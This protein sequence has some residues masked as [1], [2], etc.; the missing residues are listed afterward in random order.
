MFQKITWFGPWLV[1]PGFCCVV[2]VSEL[3]PAGV[4]NRRSSVSFDLTPGW[5]LLGQCSQQVACWRSLVSGPGLA[6]G[7]RV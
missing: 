1:V 6:Q 5:W 7:V 4:C 3:G 2:R